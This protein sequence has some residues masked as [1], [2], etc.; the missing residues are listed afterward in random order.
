VHNVWFGRTERIAAFSTTA[1]LLCTSHCPFRFLVLEQIHPPFDHFLIGKLKSPI[2]VFLFVV[3]KVNEI[4]GQIFV[5]MLDGLDALNGYFGFW[6][7]LAEIDFFGVILF[8]VKLAN[9]TKKLVL[10]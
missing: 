5:I 3:F 7:D 10:T 8:D 4:D 6:F 9:I 1:F 2:F